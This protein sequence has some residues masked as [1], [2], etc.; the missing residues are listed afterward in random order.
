M[1]NKDLKKLWDMLTEEQQAELVAIAA[2]SRHN[3][4]LERFNN[5]GAPGYEV[6]EV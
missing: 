5:H 4:D 1:D 3:R 2:A 6:K